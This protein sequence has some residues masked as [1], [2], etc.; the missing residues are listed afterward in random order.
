VLEGLVLGQGF[1]EGSLGGGFVA[2]E[3]FEGVGFFGGGADELGEEV[4]GGLILGE[5]FNDRVWDGFF[6]VVAFVVG[7][8]SLVI[9][10]GGAVFAFDPAAGALVGTSSPPPIRM[11]P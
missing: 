9:F 5:G 7:E 8:V 1:V 6:D 3:E 4:G 11:Q 10:D 2:A